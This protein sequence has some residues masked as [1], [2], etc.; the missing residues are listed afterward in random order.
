MVFMMIAI[1]I[2]KEEDR[3]NRELT[4]KLSYQMVEKAFGSSL[5]SFRHESDKKQKYY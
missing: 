4:F 3:I 1:Q 5:P 2:T